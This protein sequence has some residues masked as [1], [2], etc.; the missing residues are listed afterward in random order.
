[1]RN[2]TLR[3]K[4]IAGGL[5]ILLIPLLAIGVFSVIKSSEA[6]DNLEREQL[7]NLRRVMID[8]LNTN[9]TAQTNLLM[10]ASSHDSL[11]RRI[12]T[13]IEESGLLDFAQYNLDKH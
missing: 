12:V 13:T 10:N 7:L 1:M 8:L 5:V 3:T 4:L 9:L 11:I 2:V 6:M